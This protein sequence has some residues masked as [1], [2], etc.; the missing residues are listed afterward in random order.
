MAF[1]DKALLLDVELPAEPVGR[2]QQFTVRWTF[3]AMQPI[4][5]GWRIF[6]HFEGPGGARFQGDHD[7]VRPFAWWREGDYIRYETTVA[8]PRRSKKGA[9]RL[10][11]GIYRGGKR[12][13]V[14]APCCDVLEGNRVH[15]GTV[16]VR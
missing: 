13:G 3:R 11:V 14:Q 9:Y 7:P 12:L 5:D 10:M 8:V 16:E 6:A 2:D 15:V 4:G 1:D